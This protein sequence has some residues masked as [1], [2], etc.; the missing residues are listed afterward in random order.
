MTRRT[1]F[2]TRMEG[3]SRGPRDRR[4]EARARF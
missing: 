2:P 4:R 1:R 3:G